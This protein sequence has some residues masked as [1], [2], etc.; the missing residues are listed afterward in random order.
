MGARSDINTHLLPFARPPERRFR[1]PRLDT[2]TTRVAADLIEDVIGHRR[3]RYDPPSRDRDI[4]P[5]AEM[6]HDPGVKCRV[7]GGGGVPPSSKK[8]RPV[9]KAADFPSFSQHI[10]RIAPDEREWG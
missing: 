3:P 2:A 6:S 8:Y 7:G 9:A 5:N 10:T 1:R 4:M